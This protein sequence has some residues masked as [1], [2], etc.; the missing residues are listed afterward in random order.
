MKNYFEKIYKGNASDFYKAIKINLKKNIKTFIITANPE[1][2]IMGQNDEKF[3]AV[4][5]DKKTI[6]VPD[7]IGIVKAGKI[8]G[9]EIKERIPGIDIAEKLLEYSSELKKTVY[10]YG[11]KQEVLEKMKKMIIEKYSNLVLVGM[12]NGYGNNRDKDF[13]EIEKLKP[14]VIL[15]ALGMKYQEMLIYKNLAKF[16]KGIFVGVGGS[17]DVLSGSKKRAPE[18]FR[19]LN[20]EWLYRILKEPSRMKR[21]YDNNIKFLIKIKK[22]K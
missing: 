9:Y 11:S 7:G 22:Y 5:I 1:T 4:L 2:F 3:N 19:K 8:F 12:K 14:D 15:V 18:I 6:I 17:F 16:E 10:L 20:L 21:F 13:E